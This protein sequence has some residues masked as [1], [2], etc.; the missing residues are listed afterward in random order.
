MI[1]TQRLVIA[2]LVFA[3]ITA[4]TSIAKTGADKSINQIMSQIGLIMEQ[5]FP[6]ML[7]EKKF[8]QAATKQHIQQ[9]VEK[10]DDLFSKARPHFDIK[11]P[12]YRISFDVIKTQLSDVDT[13]LKYKN[14]NYARNIL[15]EFVS[16]CTSCHTQDEKTRTLFTGISEKHFENDLQFAEF[17]YM[18]RN[19]DTAVK[20]YDQYLKKTDDISETE[21]LTVMKRILTI[22][23]QVENDP[24]AALDHLAKLKNYP[25]HT[26]FTKNSLNQWIEGLKDLEK[27][28][29]SKVVSPDMKQLQMYVDK[30]LGPLTEPG[31][32][33][34]P[35]KKEKVARVWLRG[36]LYHYLNSKPSKADIPRILYWLA[37]ID[38]TIDYSFYYSLSDL[39]LK[40]CM[41]QYT[42]NPYAKKCYREY[43]E[44]ITFSYSGS[45]G[46]DIPEDIQKELKA[47][48][49]RVYSAP[50]N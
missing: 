13:A 49:V 28:K 42:S 32:A 5:L 39:Y 46:T 26:K 50:P 29:V 47:L 37:I 16:I 14:Y 12:T 36:R 15:K 6:V 2:F 30:I 27:Q 25:H 48:K 9:K 7:D 24:K 10:L 8:E 41:L 44:Y 23:T 43:E 22:Y 19:Y 20:Y 4:G 45:R 38:R 33:E 3:S 31:S 21:L 40:E 18:T 1:Q 17:N 11:S 35:S 34:F